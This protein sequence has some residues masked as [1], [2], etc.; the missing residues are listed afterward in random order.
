MRIL[1]DTNVLLDVFL[2]RAPHYRHSAAIWGLAE[3]HREDVYISAISFNNIHY[4]MRKLKGKDCAQRAVEVLNAVFHIAPLDHEVLTKAVMAKAPDF[5]DAIQFYSAL[6]I[7]ADCIVSRNIKDF[8]QD[9][10]PVWSAEA[11]LAQ[12]HESH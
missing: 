11:F 10:L 2:E 6:S 5:E 12:Y 9:T 3:S 1:V 8:P 4:I 7:G